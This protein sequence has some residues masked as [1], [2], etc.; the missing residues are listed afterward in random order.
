M[1]KSSTA[2]VVTDDGQF[3][4]AFETNRGNQIFWNA[5]KAEPAHQ[6]GHAIAQIDESGVSGRDAL[7]HWILVAQASGCV[8]CESGL[9]SAAEI[10]EMWQSQKATG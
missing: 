4:C 3:F 10:E 2:G 5:A 8:L 7:V 1:P 6:N 9:R